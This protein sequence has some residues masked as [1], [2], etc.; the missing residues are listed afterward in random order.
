MRLVIRNKTMPT[1]QTPPLVNYYAEQWPRYV[2]LCVDYA[3][4]ITQFS[5]GELAVIRQEDG[6]GK[7]YWGVFP[8]QCENQLYDNLRK[9]AEN[10][11]DQLGGHQ[12]SESNLN[13]S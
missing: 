3:N 12:V 4:E 2:K 1:Q 9:Q 5:V 6:G 7:A 13:A 11:V 8:Q 10:I